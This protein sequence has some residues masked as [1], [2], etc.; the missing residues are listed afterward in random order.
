V[1]LRIDDDVP[2]VVHGDPGRLRQVLI[3]LIGNAVKF[4]E[5]GEVEVR[6]RCS[7][8]LAETVEEGRC[9]LEFSVRDTGIGMSEDAKKRIFSAFSQ[10]DGSMTRRFGGTGLGL[11]ISQQLVG[12]MGGEI[13]VES[14]P[15]AGST[16]RFRVFVGVPATMPSLPRARDELYGLRVLIIDD[17]P[18]SCAILQRHAS[19]A[20][21]LSA[22]ADCGERA[23]PILESAARRGAPYDVVLVDQKMPGMNGDALAAAISEGAGYGSPKLI[24]MTSLRAGEASSD[25]P[26][27]PGIAALVAKPVRRADLY[28][29]IAAAL[30]AVEQSTQ[31]RQTAPQPAPAIGARVLVVEDNRINQ[32]ICLA[33]LRGFGCEADIAN[34]GR[35]GR[36]AA[37]QREYDV[38][39][40]DC[41][42]PEMDGFAASAAIRE[43][44]AHVNVT[45]PA[46]TPERRVPIIALTANAMEGDRNRCLAA[47]MDDYLSKPFKK[48]Q[49]LALLQR[50]TGK[51]QLAA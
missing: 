26:L 14:A 32:Q 50:W 36:D 23:L 10:A 12:L 42:M 37:V 38:V 21:M 41:Q 39:L 27:Q 51:Q 11:V 47:G 3:N 17:K 24:M 25:T 22:S 28:A 40:M 18:A 2:P 13:D 15:A 30:G 43:H 35:E 34:N 8:D 4:T 31:T 7:P 20:G 19:A 46:G 49:L 1:L 6:V 33:M 29:C 9:A 16:F 48:D 44:E 45:R 5:R